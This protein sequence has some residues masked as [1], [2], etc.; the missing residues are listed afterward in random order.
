MH[1]PNNLFYGGHPQKD[2]ALNMIRLKNEISADQNSPTLGGGIMF[3]TKR[4]SLADL[5]QS[6][7]RSR[8]SGHTVGFNGF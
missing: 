8:S 6:C 1:E 4:R 7:R 3:Q 5:N 2:D